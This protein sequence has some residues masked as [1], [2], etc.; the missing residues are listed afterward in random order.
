MSDTMHEGPRLPA[1]L[2]EVRGHFQSD[3]ALQDAVARLEL[4]GFDRSSLSVPSTGSA[5]GTP[6]SGA[7]AP[8]T[9]DDQRQIRVLGSSTAA[10]A[11]AMVGAGVV[12][13]T[14]GAAAVAMAAAAGL[15]LASGGATYAAVDAADATNHDGRE[16]AAA[17]GEL[18]LTVLIR[19]TAQGEP[20][21]AQKAVAAMHD[22][23][24]DS[25]RTVQ[26]DA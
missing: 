4:L 22:A 24:A 21:Q 25:V 26:R 8:N 20:E 12:V 3:A 18:I 17:A 1:T 14:G 7:G 6:E 23:G 11:G 5:H 13:A 2:T 15:G 9:D 10:V 19:Q 16:Q